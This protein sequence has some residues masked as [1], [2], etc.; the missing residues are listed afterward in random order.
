[1]ARN[2]PM[3]TIKD[4]ITGRKIRIHENLAGDVKIFCCF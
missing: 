3:K 1:M 4:P 2:E